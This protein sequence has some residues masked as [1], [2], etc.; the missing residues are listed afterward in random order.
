MTTRSQ[1]KQ[2]V[3]VTTMS[4]AAGAAHTAPSLSPTPSPVADTKLINIRMLDSSILVELRYATSRNI[5]QRPLYPADMPALVRPSVARR[6]VAAQTYLVARGFRLK[7]WDAYRPKAAQDELWRLTQNDHFVAN[8]ADG[9][10]SLHT[11]G[12]AVDATLVDILGRDVP[13]PTDFDAFTADAGMHYHGS[14]PIVRQNL[15]TLQRGMGRAGF[16]G[17]SMEWWHF[18][19]PDWKQYSTIP[20]LPF[21]VLP[22]P[23][24][25]ESSPPAPVAGGNAGLPQTRAGSL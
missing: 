24:V 14:D 21:L 6:L 13:M 19:A 12:V 1:I 10:G 8:P 16:Y 5:A 2:L 11:R 3:L 4:L 17:L 18:V 7:I 15:R 22:S 20:E 23:P 9:V 25:P